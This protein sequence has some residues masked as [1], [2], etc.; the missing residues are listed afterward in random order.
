MNNL[1]LYEEPEISR[2]PLQH[3]C[4]QIKLLQSNDKN[5]HDTNN[6]NNTARPSIGQFIA[7][8]IEPPKDTNSVKNAIYSLSQ[9]NALDSQEQLT[10][11]GN[12]NDNK[13][14]IYIVIYPA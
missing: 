2:I 9:F 13:K 3:L 8:L 4:L 10:P 7:E 1:Q 12:N 11:L 5:S 6:N 14:P